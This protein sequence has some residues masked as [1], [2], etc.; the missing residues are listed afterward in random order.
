[1][2]RPRPR[3][4][5]V[6]TTDL[7]AKSYGARRR[8]IC[9]AANAPTPTALNA[10]IRFCCCVRTMRWPLANDEPSNPRTTDDRRARWTFAVCALPS[11]AMLPARRT[12]PAHDQTLQAVVDRLTGGLTERAD[13]TDGWVTAV[14]RMAPS[15]PRYAPF[16]DNVDARLRQVLGARGIEQLY[17]HQAAA[18]EHALA[19]RNV[20][21]TTPTASGKTLC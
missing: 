17:T 1:M 15:A 9:A 2:T 18:V 7:P 6:I 13:T 21:V 14:R 16:P 19:G 8:H 20:V 12:D 3:D 10:S 4:P 5:P 11:P